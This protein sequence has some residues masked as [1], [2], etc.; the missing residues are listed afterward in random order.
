MKDKQYTTE[1]T[2]AL[3]AFKLLG[4]TDEECIGFSHGFRLGVSAEM[5]AANSTEDEGI[6]PVWRFSFQV[7]VKEEDIQDYIATC[8]KYNLPYTED[9]S[10]NSKYYGALGKEPIARDNEF[11]QFMFNSPR[12]FRE[13]LEEFYADKP[14]DR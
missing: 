1:V 9:W 11:A 7:R 6:F 4:F 14:K 13:R 10:G 2:K 5:K 3:H 12:F 8:E